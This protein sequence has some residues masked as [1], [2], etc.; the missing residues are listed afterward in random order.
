LEGEDEQSI[1][2]QMALFQE[3]VLPDLAN[4]I[5]CGNSLIGPDFHENQQMSLLDEEEMYRVNA[6]DWE[7]EFSEIMKKDG[8]DAVIGNPPYGYVVPAIQQE[9][10]SKHYQYQNHQKDLYLLFFERYGYFL[11]SHGLIGIIVSNTWLQSVTFRRIR[12]YLTTH[13]NWLRILHLPDKVFRAIIDTHVLIFQKTATHTMKD[14]YLSVDIRR[15]GMITSSHTLPWQYIPRTGD[16]INII[17]PIEGQK[18]FRKVQDRSSPLLQICKIYNGTKPFEKGKGKPPQTE[19]I[20]KEKPYVREG[21]KPAPTWSPLLRGSLIRRYENLWKYN[22]W[23]LY[24]HWLAAPRDPAIFD[25]PLKIMVRQTGDS[26]IA[27]L[28]EKSFIARNNLHILLPRDMKYD[29]RYILGIMN[30]ILIDFAYYLV[31]PE[32]GEALAEIK[33]HHVEQLPIRVIDFSDSTDKVRH[34]RM[35]ELVERMLDLNKQLA[36]AKAPQTKT[37]LQRQIETINKQIDQLVYKLYDL[38][39]EEIKIVESET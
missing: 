9:Y 16:P 6:F 22:Y 12:Q 39:D 3:R 29:L 15:G 23:I 13:Y 17:V 33:K 28:I 21:T 26:I 14:E 24:G 32:K 30:S 25:A 19:Q 8:F 4:N 1:G 11:K 31:N 35:I 18:L 34:D 5:K 27:T 10:F 7:T 37:V 36:E 20:M 38:T 2:K